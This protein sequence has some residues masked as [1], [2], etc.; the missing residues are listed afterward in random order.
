MKKDDNIMK[1]MKFSKVEDD[2]NTLK[3]ANLMLEGTPLCLDFNDCPKDQGDKVLYFL[4][5]VNYS[6]DGYVKP[7]SKNIFIFALKEHYKDPELKAFIQ[8]YGK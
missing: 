2:S 4:S 3:F 5:G 1:I 8:K 7:L 6:V